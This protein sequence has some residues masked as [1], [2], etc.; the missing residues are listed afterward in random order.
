MVPIAGNHVPGI[1]AIPECLIDPVPVVLQR[2]LLRDIPGFLHQGNLLEIL[3]Q[4]GLAWQE[5]AQE[6]KQNPK[7]NLFHFHHF[8]LYRPESGWLYPPA[9]GIKG[10]KPPQ[11]KGQSRRT[12]GFVEANRQGGR[13]SSLGQRTSQLQLPPFLPVIHRE[14]G[15]PSYRH[16]PKPIKNQ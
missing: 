1:I 5:A 11:P 8:L 9:H 14:S 13:V 2:P 3:F 10:F 6:Q 4:I 7:Q 12:T 15:S 16:Q